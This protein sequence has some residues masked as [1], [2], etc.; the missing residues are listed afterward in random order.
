MQKLLLHH[1]QLLKGNFEIKPLNFLFVF[2]VKCPGC[3]LHGIPLVNEL[4]K[5]FKDDLSFLGLSTAF[6]DFEFNNKENTQKLLFNHEV[7]G[8]TKKSLNT[9]EIDPKSIDIEFPVA[10]DSQSTKEFDFKNSAKQICQINPNYKIWPE[11]EQNA[12]EDKVITYLKNLEQISLTFT[13]NQFKG[14]PTM[15]V[16]NNEYEILYHK[17]GHTDVNTIKSKLKE[18]IGNF[19]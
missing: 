6:E 19:G 5:E 16:F 12:L 10:M 17:F 2:Q 4:Y 18:L 7:V 1:D 11:F 14:T 9:Y 8:E 3:F 15:I 13:L